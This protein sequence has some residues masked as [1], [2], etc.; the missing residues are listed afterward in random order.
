MFVPD[1]CEVRRIRVQ[2]GPDS[3]HDPLPQNCRN[4]KA[5]AVMRR[6]I[7]KRLV[8]GKR[9]LNPI[10]CQ[11]I[12]EVKRMN[13][14][15]DPVGGNLSQLIH[16]T[17]DLRQ[18]LGEALQIILGNLQPCQSS[19]SSN[20]IGVEHSRGLRAP[21][22]SIDETIG[23][24]RWQRER[25][26]ANRFANATAA[27]ALRAD[28]LGANLT[29]RKSDLDGLQVGHKSATGDPCDLGADTPQV[30]RL[31]AGFH[32]V[33]NLGRLAANFTRPRH[34]QTRHTRKQSE[35]SK[36]FLGFPG[37]RSISR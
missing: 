8:A 27:D 10:G 32:H 15:L 4:E 5:L 6:C 20:F 31:T 24:L 18:F 1:F 23:S 21:M 35:L 30:F 7:A 14:W 22:R 3:P 17:Y 11:N 2:K 37:E 12:L 36:R 33:A 26:V 9:W 16:Q 25:L 28:A 34:D 29:T 13:H 19:E